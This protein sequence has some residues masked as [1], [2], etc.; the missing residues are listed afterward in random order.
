MNQLVL[1]NPSN[2]YKPQVRSIVLRKRGTM[3][4]VRLISLDS[5]L[6]YIYSQADDKQEGDWRDG[7]V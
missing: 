5:L 7:D 3:R 2:D 6:A 1:S 4:G